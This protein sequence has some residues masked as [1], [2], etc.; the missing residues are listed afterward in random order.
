MSSVADLTRKLAH[1]LEEVRQ[2][3]ARGLRSKLDAGLF[4][5]PDLALEP[6]LAPHLVRML[7]LPVMGGKLDAVALIGSLAAHESSS[8]Q[9]AGLGAIASLQGLQAD[10]AQAALH[11]A[12]AAAEQKLVQQPGAPVVTTVP[13]VMAVVA[14]APEHTPEPVVKAEA[15]APRPPARSGAGAASRSLRFDGATTEAL[16]AAAD[17]HAAAAAL[18]RGRSTARAASADAAPTAALALVRSGAPPPLA[19]A[20]LG[21]PRLEAC[22]EQ[23]LFEA[24]VRIAACAAQGVGRR[25][26]IPGQVTPG[27]PLTRC[28]SRWPSTGCCWALVRCSRARCAAAQS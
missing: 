2:R 4:E 6:S 16:A 9:L 20:R 8:K 5:L 19:W 22:D 28:G 26:L 15:P 27:S 13:A 14:V 12:A 23:L 10:P 21:S 25:A 18:P 24:T 1:P 11:D 17:L 3:S 7:E